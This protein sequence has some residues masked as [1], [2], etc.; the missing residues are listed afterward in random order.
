MVNPQEARYKTK[1]TS[2]RTEMSSAR[3]Q[4]TG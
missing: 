3:S 4:L 2:D 1:Q